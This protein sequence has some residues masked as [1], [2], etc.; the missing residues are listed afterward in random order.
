MVTTL[1][2]GALRFVNMGF[3]VVSG[4]NLVFDM[5]KTKFGP[6]TEVST[7][8]TGSSKM[9]VGRPIPVDVCMLS[10]HAWYVKGSSNGGS[11]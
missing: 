9:W 1:H 8:E 5:P 7:N 2:P 4:A 3:S 11:G 6:N 10:E